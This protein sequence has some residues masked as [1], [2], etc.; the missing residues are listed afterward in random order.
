MIVTGS[1]ARYARFSVI[2]TP[3][4]LT[5]PLRSQ[6]VELQIA[7]RPINTQHR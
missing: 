6:S 1:G 7:H 2:D 3:S 5:Q 4:R